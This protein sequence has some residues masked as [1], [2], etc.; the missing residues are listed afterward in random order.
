[1]ETEPLVTSSPKSADVGRAGSKEEIEPLLAL[2]KAGRLFDVQQWITDGKPVNLPP[3]LVKGRQVKAP[4]DV[5]MEMGFHSLVE[6][7]LRAGA[8]QEPAAGYG[9]PI[10]QALQAR[11]LDIVELLVDHGADPRAVDMAQVL[12][13]WDPKVFNF[14]ISRGA[15]VVKGQPFAYA[16][17]HRVRTALYAFKDLSAQR[18][19]LMEQANIALRHHCKAGDMKW[20]SLLLWVGADPLKPGPDEPSR[21]A[22][23]D[24]TE[25]VDT[26][27][28]V[29]RG[30][31]ALGYAALYQHFEV[32]KLKPVRTQLENLQEA[33]FMAYLNRGEG[34]DILRRL[35]EKGWT[36]NDQENGGSSILS[37][38]VDSLNWSG[39]WSRSVDL[40]PSISTRRKF[41]T[42][43]ARDTMKAIHILAKHGARWVPNDK[44][45][46]AQTRRS[47]MQMT[48]DYTIEFVWIMAKYGACELA[49][50]K[51]LL[52]TPTMKSNTAAHRERLDILLQQ[53]AN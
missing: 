5:A 18:P 34:V 31:S 53:W 51:E 13:S 44:N 45:A 17:C 7:L 12:D 30:L 11:R 25:D 42:S 8:I 48:V 22:V 43:E 3:R 15:D 1:M 19:E 20:V 2:C 9:S 16:F 50:L 52:G 21:D 29:Y 38:F 27:D 28:D 6:V 40:W 36:P 24:G 37:R 32:F 10:A 49:P 33:D 14:F 47:L 26:N 23:D 39:R 46:I 35:L 4:L 41:D